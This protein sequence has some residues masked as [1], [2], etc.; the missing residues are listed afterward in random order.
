M[1]EVI[2]RHFNKLKKWHDAINSKTMS[3]D[4]CLELA[5]LRALLIEHDNTV[6]NGGCL[7]IVTEDGNF[8]DDSVDWCINYMESGEW[9]E[10]HGKWFTDEQV[11][12]QL[13]LAKQLRELTEWEREMVC[14]GETM[15]EDVF[16]FLM[17]GDHSGVVEE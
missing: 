3:F 6:S 11:A 13:E 1:T 16:N 10:V 15:N 14:N 7:H 5:P 4:R 9:K 17:N 2:E 8:E 12:E